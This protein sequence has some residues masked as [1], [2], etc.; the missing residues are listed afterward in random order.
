MEFKIEQEKS[1]I[2]NI[3]KIIRISVEKTNS[4][5]ETFEFAKELSSN[6]LSN[7]FS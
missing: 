5:K 3:E 4:E 7:I 2:V 1:Y 6:S